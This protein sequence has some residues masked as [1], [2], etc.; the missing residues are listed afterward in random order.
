MIDHSGTTR[1]DYEEVLRAIGYFVDHNNLK[2]VTII[3]LNE[4]MLVRGVRYTTE[5]AAGY[6]TISETFLFTNDDINQILEDAYKRRKP[7]KGG[8]FRLKPLG[9]E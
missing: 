2:E 1:V 5:P 4:G 9:K 6:Q 3:E 7:G 8:I